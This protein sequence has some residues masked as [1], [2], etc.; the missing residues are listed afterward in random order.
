MQPQQ[1]AGQ[2]PQQAPA[3]KSNVW[4]WILAGCLIIVILTGLVIAGLGWWGVRKVKKEI[5]KAQ[6]KLEEWS[7]NADEWQKQSEELQKKAQ[8]LQKNLPQTPDDLDGDVSL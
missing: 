5:D 2:A 3:K 1:P 4:I 7:K 8:E 6:P